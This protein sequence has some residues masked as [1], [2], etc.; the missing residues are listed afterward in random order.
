MCFLPMF[1]EIKLFHHVHFVHNSKK[2]ELNNIFLRYVVAMNVEKQYP[3]VLKSD[4]L[5]WLCSPIHI[6]EVA[7]CVR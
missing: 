6:G 3:T 5:M 7:K 1:I 4:V 2:I